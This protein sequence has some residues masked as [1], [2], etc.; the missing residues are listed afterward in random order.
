MKLLGLREADQRKGASLKRPVPETSFFNYKCAVVWHKLAT[1]HWL[2][3]R[4]HRVPN[5]M[6]TT[7]CFGF[8]RIEQV[9]F[10]GEVK[11]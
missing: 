9:V 10:V 8:E 7:P 1:Q 3:S 6:Q 2:A 11:R 4:L 5:E